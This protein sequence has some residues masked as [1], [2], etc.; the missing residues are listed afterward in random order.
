MEAGL[1]FSG[2]IATESALLSDAAV[3]E[4][5]CAGDAALF[6]VLMRRYNQRIY[7]AVRSIV[8]E[9]A[10]VEDVM[11]QAY[12]SAFRHLGEFKGRSSVATWLTRIAVNAAISRLR[13]QCRF[14]TSVPGEDGEDAMSVWPSTAPDP[15]QHAI[16]HEF[17]HLLEMAVDAL[18]PSYRTVFVLREVE[19]L[20]TAETAEVLGL[21]ES[22]VKTRL[23]R[24]K[25]QLREQLHARTQEVAR[26]LFPFGGTRC[27]RVVA[28]VLARLPRVPNPTQA[29]SM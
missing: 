19:G 29:P 13:I 15:E 11:Q 4:R 26:A 22:A 5:V 20:S 7:R 3:V 23:H 2:A 16:A 10:E 12:L 24:A 1:R 6:E 8:R 27:D 21:A 17:Q 9:E 28:T 14:V 18:P 25:V